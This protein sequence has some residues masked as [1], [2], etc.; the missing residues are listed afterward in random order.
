VSELPLFDPIDLPPNTVLVDINS[1]EDDDERH[2][3]QAAALELYTEEELEGE[4]EP[5]EWDNNE[6]IFL[7][8]ED[9]VP[10]GIAIVYDVEGL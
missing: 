3:Y 10:I 5:R 6:G 1:I 4:F 9:G 2:G 8:S 7:V